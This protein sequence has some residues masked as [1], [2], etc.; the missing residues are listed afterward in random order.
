MNRQ[1]VKIERMKI[2]GRAHW[3]VMKMVAFSLEHNRSL[4]LIDA[5]PGAL[6]PLSSLLRSAITGT[7]YDQQCVKI[8][9][10]YLNLPLTADTNNP[11]ELRFASTNPLRAAAQSLLYFVRFFEKDPGLRVHNPI[12]TG[13]KCNTFFLR[14]NSRQKV[15]SSKCRFEVWRETNPHGRDYWKPDKPL[16]RK[17]KTVVKIK[18]ELPPKPAKIHR[19]ARKTQRHENPRG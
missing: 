14:S 10:S 13:P 15:C 7:P 11:M 5:E 4:G 12:A 6:R 19:K 8:V 18:G 9:E 16:A 17:R 3:G 1:K 2:E